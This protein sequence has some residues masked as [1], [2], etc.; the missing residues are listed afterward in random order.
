M[1]VLDEVLLSIITVFHI[2]DHNT[3]LHRVNEPVDV[4]DM[5]FVAP[6]ADILYFLRL[7]Y[8]VCIHSDE[9]SGLTI[10]EYILKA[11]EVKG[12]S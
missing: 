9:E 4:N 10:L 5:G 7:I 2:R 11:I 1:S 12:H 6:S 3:L 8:L